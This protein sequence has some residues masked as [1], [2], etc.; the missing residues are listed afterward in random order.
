MLLLLCCSGLSSILIAQDYQTG[1]AHYLQNDFARAEQIFQGLAAQTRSDAEHAQVLKLLG[2]S[3]YMQGKRL[4]SA[5]SFKQAK[6]FAPGLSIAPREVLDDTVLDFF[7]SIEGPPPVEQPLQEAPKPK[8]P[9]HKAETASPKK[10]EK[11]TELLVL[12][13][14]IEAKI[15]V[16]GFYRGKVGDLI[17]IDPGLHN[18]EIYAS[19]YQNEIQTIN[20]RRAAL[21]KVKIKLEKLPVLSEKKEEEP[22][23]EV[24]KVAET[25][26]DQQVQA[27]K[28]AEEKRKLAHKKKKRRKP[29]PPPPPPPEDEW[30]WTYYFP[31]GVPQYVQGKTWLGVT[32]TVGQAAGLGFFTQRWLQANTVS[33]ETNTTVSQRDVEEATITNATQRQAF[34]NATDAY[35]S[36]Q[37]QDISNLRNQAYYGLGFFALAW[38]ASTIE[39]F[40]NTPTPTSHADASSA[41]GRTPTALQW[42]LAPSYM[43]RRNAM[44]EGTFALNL[45]FRF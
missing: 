19:S 27:E 26:S 8:E 6:R 29:P 24:A 34:A 3:Q 36:S 17:P 31:F 28:D 23:K 40:V 5:E 1:L 38:I 21:N 20:I 13:N 2:L 14:A 12:S 4:E 9:K 39:A 35:Y 22:K 7:S 11:P 37:V 15:V 16:D 10:I 45:R 32:F 44:S 33:D 25:K 43:P 42:S 18:I 41:I 30:E